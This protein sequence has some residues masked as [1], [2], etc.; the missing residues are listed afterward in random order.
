MP[1]SMRT[2]LLNPRKKTAQKGPAAAAA[3]VVAEQEVAVSASGKT[4]LGPWL[5]GWAGGR[6]GLEGGWRAREWHIQGGQA[7][8]RGS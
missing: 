5:G 4:A 3:V 8:A 6:A 2:R 7:G 1:R